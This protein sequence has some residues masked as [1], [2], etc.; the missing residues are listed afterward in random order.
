MPLEVRVYRAEESYSAGD[1]E[2]LQLTPRQI[3]DIQRIL[4]SRA[5]EFNDKGLPI[6]FRSDDGN[7]KSS[8]VRASV[9]TWEEIIEKAKKQSEE[10]KRKPFEPKDHLA[11]TYD[12]VFEGGAGVYAHSGMRAI[13]DSAIRD[14]QYSE[15]VI[16]EDDGGHGL[17]G[18]ADGEE[19]NLRITYKTDV[20]GTEDEL[21]RAMDFAKEVGDSNNIQRVSNALGYSG[22][23]DLITLGMPNIKTVHV[24]Y[25]ADEYEA[26]PYNSP[27][28][29]I[30]T[31]DFRLKSLALALLKRDPETFREQFGD[32]FVA[33]Y[34]WG[35]RFEAMLTIEDTGRDLSKAKVKKVYDEINSFANDMADMFRCYSYYEYD[36]SCYAKAED[37]KAK[38]LDNLDRYKVSIK[39]LQHTGHSTA[40]VSLDLNGAI[41]D[42]LS[43]VNSAKSRPGSEYERLYAYLMRYR[44]IPEAYSYIDKEL[45]IKA[46]AYYRIGDLAQ[47]IYCTRSLYNSLSRIPESR[48]RG[49]AD[50]GL[51][52]FETLVDETRLQ[53]NRICNEADLVE[54]Y[55][56]RFRNLHDD[57][58]ALVERYAFYRY[59]VERQANEPT[60][61]WKSSPGGSGGYSVGFT[62]YDKSKVVNDDLSQD[63]EMY[64]MYHEEPCT[65]GPGEAT[66][67]K[68]YDPDRYNNSRIFWYIIKWIKTKGCSCED[69]QGGI[70]GRTGFH[71]YFDCARSRRMEVYFGYRMVELPYSKYPFA[72]LK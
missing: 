14:D 57:Y 59:F 23:D 33:G 36:S 28:A 22:K 9:E 49:G 5:T 7:V 34:T 71:L 37:I 61:T 66:F 8:G 26:R 39:K 4:L 70:L 10:E 69:H 54:S 32:Y 67:K 15:I 18:P 3:V 63:K 38:L 35:M 41:T 25:Q 16:E 47:K 1:D 29:S 12:D 52:R 45:P 46:L 21:Y 48:L 13:I 60:H 58:E 55:Y 17:Y 19:K 2:E 72:G 56:G 20:I 40:G 27:S 65:G 64:Y 43:F 31:S 68:N 30:N 53:I 24:V 11:V 50:L 42:F 6:A 44:E 51:R 62:E